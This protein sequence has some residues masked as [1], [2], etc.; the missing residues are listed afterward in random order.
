M[1]KAEEA[2]VTLARNLASSG[3]NIS[4]IHPTRYK[5]LD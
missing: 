1:E 4:K 2:T 3:E 5:T